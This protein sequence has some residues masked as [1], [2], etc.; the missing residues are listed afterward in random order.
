M[1]IASVI[2]LQ[3]SKNKSRLLLWLSWDSAWLHRNYIPTYSFHVLLSSHPAC[4]HLLHHCRAS[5]H[6]QFG[7]DTETL[8]CYIS[9]QKKSHLKFFRRSK[10]VKGFRR[11]RNKICGVYTSVLSL[12]HQDSPTAQFETRLKCLC[13]YM[14]SIVKAQRPRRMKIRMTKYEQWSITLFWQCTLEYEIFLRSK[15]SHSC[16]QIL[17]R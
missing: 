7:T 9:C 3:L 5:Q 16:G 11:K 15:N 6:A 13:K 14:R 8:Q 12:S 2:Y 10:Q 1:S 17:T 4:L